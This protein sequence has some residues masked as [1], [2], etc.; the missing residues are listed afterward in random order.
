MLFYHGTCDAFLPAIKRVGL[1]PT[2]TNNFRIDSPN[3]GNLRTLEGKTRFVYLTPNRSVAEFFA[4]YRSWFERGEVGEIVPQLNMLK[5]GGKVIPTAKPVVLT[6][7]VPKTIAS[8]LSHDTLS[9]G[10]VYPGDIP[11]SCIVK[12]ARIRLRAISSLPP[13]VTASI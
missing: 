4:L 13:S 7:D 12:V 1:K 5:T 10:L 6:L 11:A 9:H 2:P 3:A 8:R